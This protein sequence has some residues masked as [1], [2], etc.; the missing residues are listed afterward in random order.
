VAENAINVVDCV[1]DLNPD[2]EVT[3][4]IAV[5]M[6]AETNR[7]LDNEACVDP[8]NKIEE[9]V[10]PGETDNC[11]TA[12]T[13]V[14]PT[15]KKSPD[16]KVTKTASPDVV[17]P[18]GAIVYTIH[19][20]N[21]GNADAQTPLTLTDELAATLTHVSSSGTNGWT[22]TFSAPT[23][24]CNDG[25]SGLA[26]GASTDITINVTT[27]VDVSSPITNTATAASATSDPGDPDAEHA[28]NVANNHST[29]VTSI[30][31]PGFA[32]SSRTSWTRRTRPC[33]ASP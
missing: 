30:G 26:Q 4:D 25:G 16:L 13:P 8:D 23:V 27:P 6:T 20:E 32:S 18:G 1:G 33:A 7:S 9:F 11:S 24:T 19:V 15:T 17:T 10:P 31:T 29:V 14:L 12:T 28:T 3:I 22:C 21:A 2:Q 5:F